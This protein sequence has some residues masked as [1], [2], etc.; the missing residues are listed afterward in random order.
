MLQKNTFVLR[1]R[2]FESCT[3]KIIVLGRQIC[4][5]TEMLIRFKVQEL[6]LRQIVCPSSVKVM[7]ESIVSILPQTQMVHVQKFIRW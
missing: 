2:D 7:G 1:P 5:L 3:T 6:L 4:E